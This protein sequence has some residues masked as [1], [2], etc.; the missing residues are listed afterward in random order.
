MTTAF[1]ATHVETVAAGSRLAISDWRLQLPTALG[2]GGTSWDTTTYLSRI[3]A[4]VES[5]G[6]SGTSVLQGSAKLGLVGTADTTYGGLTAEATTKLVGYISGG[7]AALFTEG[8]AT[9]LSTITAAPVR[10][11][12]TA[13]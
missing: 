9:D 4:L 5:V 11:Y 10:L 3:Y 7:S 2:T 13:V 6:V 1:A 8:G 12:G